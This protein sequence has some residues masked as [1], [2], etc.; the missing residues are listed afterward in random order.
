[1]QELHAGTDMKKYEYLEIKKII[2][3]NQINWSI[4]IFGRAGVFWGCGRIR[5]QSSIM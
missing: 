2:P 3:I 5:R 4:F 1:M